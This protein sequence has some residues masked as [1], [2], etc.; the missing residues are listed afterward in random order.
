[1]KAYVVTKGSYS[2]YRIVGVFNKKALAE[3]YVDRY[4]LVHPG[5]YSGAG[6]EE[7]EM[8][9]ETFAVPRPTLKCFVPIN[10]ETMELRNAVKTERIFIDPEEGGD[11]PRADTG[12]AF[13]VVVADSAE[14]GFKIACDWWAQEKAGSAEGRSTSVDWVL[15][16]YRRRVQLATDKEAFIAANGEEAWNLRHQGGT[17]IAPMLPRPTDAFDLGAW[18]NPTILPS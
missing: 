2:D 7:Y 5:D 9:G 10:L 8:N 13:V 16:A 11:E 3:Q 18:V 17:L 12:N 1:M 4:N 15:S 14:L 6:I